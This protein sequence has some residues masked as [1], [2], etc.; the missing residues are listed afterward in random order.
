MS[1][2]EIVKTFITALQSGDMEVAANDMSDDF[3]VRGW[4]PYPLDKEKFLATQSALL[5]A[6]PDFSYN[7]SDVHKAGNEVEAL[8]QVTGTQ[9]N[10]LDL[11]MHGMPPFPATGLAIDLPQVQARFVLKEHKVSEMSIESV[12]GGGLAG[13]LQQVGTELPVAPRL[14]EEFQPG[15]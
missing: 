14:D 11:P 8:I 3:V 7:L 9:T 15:F 5:D 1:P 10:D 6:M 4:T 13:L 12:P 2:T